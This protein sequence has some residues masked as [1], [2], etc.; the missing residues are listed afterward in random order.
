MFEKGILRRAMVQVI[1]FLFLVFKRCSQRFLRCRRSEVVVLITLAELVELNVDRLVQL[2]DLGRDLRQFWVSIPI[3][4]V[5]LGELQS[6]FCLL[7]S[8]QL[9]RRVRSCGE[10]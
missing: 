4:R 6:Q 3:L 2:G 7:R 10:Q 1:G 5:E 9:Q 8:Q